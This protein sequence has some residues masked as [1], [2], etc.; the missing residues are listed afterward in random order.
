MQARQVAALAES[1]K[2]SDAKIRAMH[3]LIHDQ[4]II[5][6]KVDFEIKTTEKIERR[7]KEKA[8]G[9][10]REVRDQELFNRRQALAKLLNTEFEVWSN[11]CIGQEET[12]ADRKERYALNARPQILIIY[13]ILS[14][15]HTHL[16]I[17]VW[18]GLT[19]HFLTFI[20]TIIPFHFYP[21]THVESI[22][23][24]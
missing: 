18:S 16:F 6:S 12:M 19:F 21:Q 2:K 15:Q 22:C 13:F 11:E 8:M 5:F 1:R 20:L 24:T 9:A 14:I 4:A 10:L 17:Y 7:R 3:E 23:A